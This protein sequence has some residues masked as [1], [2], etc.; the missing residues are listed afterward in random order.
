VLSR[1]FFSLRCSEQVI[2]VG[3]DLVG[4]LQAL[5]GGLKSR[6]VAALEPEQ[7]VMLARQAG[8]VWNA[9]EI[10]LT[11]IPLQNKF[12]VTKACLTV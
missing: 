11:S 1:G 6:G 7:Q 3:T 9:C 4:S 5:I 10:G 2:A 12:A 8:L